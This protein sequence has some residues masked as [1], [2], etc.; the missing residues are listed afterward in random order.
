MA[1]IPA[2]IG[3]AVRMNAGGKYGE[4]SENIETVTCLN[5]NGDLTDQEIEIHENQFGNPS[6][7]HLY[8]D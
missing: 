2:T 4:I 6:Y 3:G 1:G 7:F 8:L 5:A